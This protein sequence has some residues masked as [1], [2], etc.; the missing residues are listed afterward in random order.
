M[1]TDGSHVTCGAHPQQGLQLQSCLQSSQPTGRRLMAGEQQQANP[2]NSTTTKDG[3]SAGGGDGEPQPE[4]AARAASAVASTGNTVTRGYGN[5]VA[6]SAIRVALSSGEGCRKDATPQN[7]SRLPG[8]VTP[9]MVVSHAAYGEY[10]QVQLFDALG[11]CVWGGYEDASL[12]LQVR[13]CKGNIQQ[14]SPVTCS[15]GFTKHT[16]FSCNPNQCLPVVS[17]TIPVGGCNACGGMP[18]RH[19]YCYATVNMLMNL[20]WGPTRRPE[21]LSLAT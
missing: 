13:A 20:L 18:C 3:S 15:T 1:V 11:Q 9:G 4:P 6:T 5:Q 19:G 2:S 7:E 14:L 17:R 8:L 16:A 12:Q 10:L 21:G